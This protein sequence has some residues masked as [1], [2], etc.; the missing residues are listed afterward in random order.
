LN[1]LAVRPS[2]HPSSRVSRTSNTLGIQDAPLRRLRSSRRW[3]FLRAGKPLL[4][5]RR[6]SDADQRAGDTPQ[7][8]ERH[9]DQ[10]FPSPPSAVV[11]LPAHPGWSIIVKGSPIGP[12]RDTTPSQK[13][14]QN[15]HRQD[16]DVPSGNHLLFPKRSRLTVIHP[17]TP[18]VPGAP[19]QEVARGSRSGTLAAVA[20]PILLARF[21]GRF[22]R[23]GGGPWRAV[24]FCRRPDHLILDFTVSSVACLVMAAWPFS[25]CSIACARFHQKRAVMARGSQAWGVQRSCAKATRPADLCA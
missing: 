9:S 12:A 8:D 23:L 21:A 20:G 25:R 22:C 4:Q 15:R 2:V 17:E 16:H 19:A 1:S 5:K 18:G 6:E 13:R 3:P 24:R 11:V 10:P 14:K 7:R